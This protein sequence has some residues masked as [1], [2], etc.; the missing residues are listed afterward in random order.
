M[1][2]EQRIARLEAIEAIKQLKAHYAEVC[3]D[4]Y[5]PDGMYPLFTEDAVWE[6]PGVF[7]R[8]DGRDAICEFF[9]G[10]S[11]P[12]SWALHYTDAPRI[13]VEDDLKGA[14]ADWYIFMP[15]TIDNAPVWLMATY[16]DRYRNEGGTWK[17]EHVAVTIQR[18]TPFDQG[19]VKVPMIGA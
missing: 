16:S 2:L 11:A 17:F 3:D 6:A 4:G 14:S 5:D 12:I 9:R 8:F 15:A 7:G 18:L 19:W 10:V 1:D 13:V